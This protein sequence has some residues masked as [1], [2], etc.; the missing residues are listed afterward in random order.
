MPFWIHPEE[1]KE[2][3]PPFS[4]P[5]DNNDFEAKRIFL[6]SIDDNDKEIKKGK[7]AKTKEELLKL[8]ESKNFKKTEKNRI[9]RLIEDL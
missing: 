7:K 8:L 9:K 6:E 4:L 3:K 5:I 1:S 2:F